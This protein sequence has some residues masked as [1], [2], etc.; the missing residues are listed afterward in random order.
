VFA[1]CR[2][3][4]LESEDP[5]TSQCPCCGSN[6]RVYSHRPVRFDSGLRERRSRQRPVGARGV[7]DS[8]YGVFLVAALIVFSLRTTLGMTSLIEMLRVEEARRVGI[9]WILP[10][11]PPLSGTEQAI[12]KIGGALFPLAF[13][14]SLILILRERRGGL[15]SL[16]VSA[17]AFCAYLVWL[18]SVTILY[19]F[20]GPWLQDD[21]VLF[22]QIAMTAV[23]CLIAALFAR[24]DAYA[25]APLGPRACV[26]RLRRVRV[27]GPYPPAAAIPLAAL[28][29]SAATYGG[30][31][32]ADVIRMVR[33]EDTYASS[34]RMKTRLDRKI[35]LPNDLFGAFEKQL[36]VLGV[37]IGLAF[38]ASLILLARGTPNGVW[39]VTG[40]CAAWVLYL[41]VCGESPRGIDPILDGDLA[42]LVRA[43]WIQVSCALLAVGIAILFRPRVARE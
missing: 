38:S 25:D 12:T 41:S 31:L 42:T 43:T 13:T 7:S 10:P 37:V 6:L 30:L 27:A 36:R 21:V 23:T 16:P 28:A 40:G 33:F 15:L 39:S 17:V 9:G 18:R 32:V 4:D 26:R 29:L 19:T 8:W 20:L 1:Y 11:P 35:P 3:C 24:R 34:D 22:T 14:V 2:S 5:R